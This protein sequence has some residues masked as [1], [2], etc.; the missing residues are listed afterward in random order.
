[1]Y[2]M[3]FN[4]V[5]ILLLPLPTLLPFLI[6]NLFTKVHPPGSAPVGVFVS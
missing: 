6:F 3:Y 2:Y 4:F 1:M 5:V